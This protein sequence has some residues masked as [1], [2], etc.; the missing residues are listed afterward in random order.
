MLVRDYMT[1]DPFTVRPE[2]DYLAA[3]AILKAASFRSL[4]VVDA[5]GRVVGIV[6]DKDLAGVAPTKLTSGDQGRPDYYGVQYKV[7]QVM[8]KDFGIVS[9]EVPLEEAAL[10]MLNKKQD[11]LLVV[12]NDNLVGIITSTDIFKQLVTTLG[13]GSG[14]TRITTQVDNSPGQLAR[15]SGAISRVGGNITSAA[16]SASNEPEKILITFRVEG[17]D[18]SVLE[19]AIQTGCEAAIIHVCGDDCR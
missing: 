11:R 4:P 9:P 14:K 1:S 19:D 2:S 13:A 16:T 8:N 15:L 10:E 7:K 3:I 5:D 12:E 6:S 17:V 18:W